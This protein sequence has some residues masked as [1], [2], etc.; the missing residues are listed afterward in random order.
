MLYVFISIIGI[1]GFL[2]YRHYKQFKK[3]KI[4][5]QIALEKFNRY[6]YYKLPVAAMAAFL[7]IGMIYTYN[8]IVKKDDMTIVIGAAIVVASIVEAVIF[9]LTMRFYYDRKRCI[10]D[11]ALIDYKQIKSVTGGDGMFVNNELT[12]YSGKK[13]LIPS[14]CRKILEEMKAI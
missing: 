13:Y 2:G 1:Y 5:N 3:R 12:T 14:Q 6:D 9:Y 11:G 4:L 7:I 8:G 10:V